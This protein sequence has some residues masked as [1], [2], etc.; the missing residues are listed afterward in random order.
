MWKEVENNCKLLV[1]NIDIRNN[2]CVLTKQK[3]VQLKAHT[4]HVRMDE[5]YC[6]ICQ[7]ELKR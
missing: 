5:T 6:H 3:T 7:A 1:K 4:C 2:I